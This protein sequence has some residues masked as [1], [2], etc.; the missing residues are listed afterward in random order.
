VVGRVLKRVTAMRAIREAV[1]LDDRD[2]DGSVLIPPP[3]RRRLLRLVLKIVLP[4][5]RAQRRYPPCPQTPPF[6][7]G[8]PE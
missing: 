6:F 3:T 4:M 1:P 2:A 8:F 5:W 7:A